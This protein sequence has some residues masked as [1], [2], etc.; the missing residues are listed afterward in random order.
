MDLTYTNQV[1]LSAFSAMAHDI[2][3]SRTLSETIDRVMH[4]VGVVFDPLNWSLLL[5][6]SKTG[7]LKFVH[8]TGPGSPALQNL[9]LHKGVGIA[10]WVAEHGEAV[11]IADT[12]DDERFNPAFDAITGFV[13]R[14]IVA[15]PLR[16]RGR[17]YG[18][19]E[20][21]NKLDESAFDSKDLIVLQT[22]ADFA[23]IAI[24]RA[25]YLGGFRRLALTDSLTGLA[26]RRAFELGLK[27]EIEKTRRDLGLFSLV[28]VD[29]DRFKV[30]NDT[31]GHGAGDEAL[32]TVAKILQRTSRKV[33]LPARIGGDE[34]AILLPDTDQDAATAV[35]SRIDRVLEAFNRS[36]AVPVAVSMGVQVVDP[37]HP[38]DILTQ[39]DKALYAQ[40]AVDRSR[41]IEGQLSSWMDEDAKD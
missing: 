10:G 29:I 16:V 21:I 11:L 36:A 2:A 33:D 1:N 25:Y 39:T 26:N 35:V 9:V 37:F 6:D 8:A 7:D 24:E 32:K 31:H 41:E 14:S 4:H 22:I 3:S 38:D 27:R 28:L 17:V 18:V 5:R 19:I 12:S 15:V 34:F 13:T 20:L 40:K 23:A 30:I